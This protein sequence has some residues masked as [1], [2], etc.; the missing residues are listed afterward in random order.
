MKNNKINYNQLEELKLKTRKKILENEIYDIL[1][2]YSKELE[3]YNST[4]KENNIYNSAAVIFLDSFIEIKDRLLDFI[5]KSKEE[6]KKLV[7]D[8]LHSTANIFS[9]NKEVYN[10]TKK[11]ISF[12]KKADSGL[13]NLVIRVFIAIQLSEEEDNNKLEKLLS[14]L[15]VQ[16]FYEVIKDKKINKEIYSNL[17][18]KWKLALNNIMKEWKINEKSEEKLSDK[19]YKIF[20]ILNKKY[21]YGI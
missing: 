12:I 4:I 14:N 5:G 17:E 20:S 6:I 11:F 15:N 8:E 7:K 18:K 3:K 16:E 9:K 21:N 13:K 10:F 2:D 1:Y 19:V